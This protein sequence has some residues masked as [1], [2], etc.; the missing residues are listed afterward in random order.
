LTGD[1]LQPI[2]G[3]GMLMVRAVG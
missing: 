1:L 3:G 2:D